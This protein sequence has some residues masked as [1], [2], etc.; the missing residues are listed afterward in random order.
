MIPESCTLI[1][2]VD[3]TGTLEANEVFVQIKRDSFSCK[4]KENA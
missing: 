4:V 1:G 2:V 3:E